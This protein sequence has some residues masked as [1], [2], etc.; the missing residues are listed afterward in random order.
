MACSRES[1]KKYVY[2]SRK[3]DMKSIPLI[4]PLMAL[5]ISGQAEKRGTVEMPQ[6]PNV[7]FIY[8]DDIGYG[9]LSCNGSKTINTPNVQRMATEE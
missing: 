4:L 3:I 6:C 5:P 2:F 8:A 7:V 9:D 1:V